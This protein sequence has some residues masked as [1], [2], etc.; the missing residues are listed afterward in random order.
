[1]NRKAVRQ[2]LIYF[3]GKIHMRI[4]HTIS[5]GFTG[6]ALARL[7]PQ[8]RPPH[9]PPPSRG[10]GSAP[11]RLRKKEEEAPEAAWVGNLSWAAQRL[12][13]AGSP[14]EASDGPRRPP[15]GGCR[16]RGRMSSAQVLSPCTAQHKPGTR[17]ARDRLAGHR[18]RRKSA[19]QPPEAVRPPPHRCEA[20]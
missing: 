11:A 19:G 17:E 16:P 7:R 18:R 5:R 1:V 2:R 20:G 12:P 14:C 4:I 13:P 9:G 8:G 15:P 6:V 3:A 10:S